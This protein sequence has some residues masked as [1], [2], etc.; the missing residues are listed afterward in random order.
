MYMRSDVLALFSK[1][2]GKKLYVCHDTPCTVENTTSFEITMKNSELEKKKC[3]GGI[4]WL[5]K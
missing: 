2:A 3:D 1:K 4:E 5:K